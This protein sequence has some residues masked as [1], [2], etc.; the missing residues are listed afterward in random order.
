MSEVLHVVML[1]AITLLRVAVLVALASVSG[2]IGVYIGLRPRLAAIA[3]PIAQF[4]R[5]FHPTVLS[6]R[7]GVIV[8]LT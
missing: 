4:L 6:G 3:Q 2:A 8:K 1:G 5:R 7:G